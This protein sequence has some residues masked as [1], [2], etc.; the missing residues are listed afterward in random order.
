M[1]PSIENWLTDEVY[2]EL[3][4]IMT[5]SFPNDL[6]TFQTFF[7]QNNDGYWGLTISLEQYQSFLD[8]L[9]GENEWQGTD[10]VGWATYTPGTSGQ[11]GSSLNINW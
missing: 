6:S 1:N 3:V 9:L 2:Q 7:Q 5:E 10:F 8:G 11:G 4:D